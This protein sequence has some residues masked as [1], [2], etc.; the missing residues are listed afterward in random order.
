M[1]HSKNKTGKGLFLVKI[2][3][4]GQSISNF[5]DKA[6]CSEL[7]TMLFCNKITESKR[8]DTTE[9]IDVY[10]TGVGSSKQCDICHSYF[11][12]NKN[13]N[14]QPYICDGCH[15]AALRAQAITE[16]KIITIK[17]GTYRVV[18]NIFT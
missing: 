12:K 9:S 4:I 11:F 15:D 1:D 8:L 10:C 6:V 17:S 5:S 18:S 16:V 7:H 3:Y 13:F 14:Y 2:F